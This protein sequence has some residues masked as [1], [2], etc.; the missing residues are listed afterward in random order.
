MNGHASRPLL[1][2]VW[3]A[4]LLLLALTVGAS[5]LHVGRFNVVLAIGIAAAKAALISLYFMNLRSSAKLIWLVVAASV[6]WLAI[7]FTLTAAD[8]ETRQYMPKATV[9]TE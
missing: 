3:A 1:V 2:T 7:L 5:F 4:L 9:W 6:L 8:Y